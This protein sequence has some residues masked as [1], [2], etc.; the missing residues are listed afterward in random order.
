MPLDCSLTSD[1]VH[2]E[3]ASRVD[4]RRIHDP[5]HNF[6]GFGA[7]SGAGLYVVGKLLGALPQEPPNDAAARNGKIGSAIAAAMGEMS[8]RTVLLIP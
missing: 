1:E 2:R 7:G 8:A 6:G 3:R 4:G 5:R